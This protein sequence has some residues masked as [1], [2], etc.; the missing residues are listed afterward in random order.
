MSGWARTALA[1]ALAAVTLVLIA[2]A[3]L[4]APHHPELVY[5]SRT[6]AADVDKFVAVGVDPGQR[7]RKCQGALVPF[8]AL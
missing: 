3:A 4:A 2:D 8:S 1:V 6:S 5:L 7:P